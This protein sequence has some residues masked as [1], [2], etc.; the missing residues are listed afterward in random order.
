M[1][2]ATTA[3]KYGT[4]LVASTRPSIG[5]QTPAATKS[6]QGWS[7]S[8]LASEPRLGSA[9]PVSRHLARPTHGRAP[10]DLPL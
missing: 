10:C 6:S 7:P 2:A 4:D 1:T 5:E 9:R 3:D 8:S